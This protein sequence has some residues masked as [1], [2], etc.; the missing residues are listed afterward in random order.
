MYIYI[1]TVS[2]D[3]VKYSCLNVVGLFQSYAWHS[4]QSTTVCCPCSCQRPSKLFE[5]N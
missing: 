5:K 1:L 2:L 3:I 4:P